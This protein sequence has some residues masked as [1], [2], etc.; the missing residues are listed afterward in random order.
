MSGPAAT[1][2]ASMS[3]AQMSVVAE[4]LGKSC[5]KDAELFNKMS[6]QVGTR[7]KSTRSNLNFD[8]PEPRAQ[9]TANIAKFKGGELARLLWGFAAAHHEDGAMAKAAA[10]ALADKAG[11][12]S[13]KEAAQAIWALA[14]LRRTDK[15]TLDALVKAAKAKGGFE[16]PIDAAA[17]AWSLGFL[18]YKDADAARSLSAALKAGAGELSAAHAIDGA[19]GLALMGGDKDAVSALFAVAAA[20]VQKDPAS[21]DVY[22]M[23]ALY[24]AAVLVPGAKLPEQVQAFALKMY[25]LGG[26]SMALKRSSAGSA[27]VQELGEAVALALGARYRPEVA[28]AVKSYAS[29]S[30][31]GVAIDIA[32]TLDGAKIAVEPVYPGYASATHPNVML[33]PA[34]ARAGLLEAAGYKVVQVPFVEFVA[35]ADTKAKAAYILN[36]LK[37]TGAKVD[38]LQKKLS[39][40]F[41]AYAE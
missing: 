13:S 27:F 15:A 30:A 19:W 41:D 5:V 3:P 4:A 7:I 25:N 1:L 6:T 11:E 31:D 32:V 33:G 26:E 40:P 22:Q 34:A 17:M 37:S 28:K 24:N 10:K 2:L 20:A 23:G 21:V 14:K 12:L 8:S 16:S 36:A 39:E 29:V 35:L 18:T 38:A 9:A